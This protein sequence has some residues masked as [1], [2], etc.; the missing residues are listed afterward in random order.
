M[1]GR[2]RRV[3]ALAFLCICVLLVTDMVSISMYD[4]SWDWP[5]FLEPQRIRT[6]NATG[7]DPVDLSYLGDTYARDEEVSQ[8]SCPD[9]IRARV[10][11]SP[12]KLAFLKNVPVLQWLKHVSKKEYDRLHKYPGAHGWRGVS[13]LDLVDTLSALNTSANRVMF[14]DWDQRAQGSS[15][16]RCA[17]IGNGGILRG[18]EKGQEIDRHH[19][20]F[21]VN[22]AVIKGFEEDVGSRTSFYTFSTNT[23]RNSMRS[24]ARAGFRGPPKS[25][26]TRYIFLP[27]QGRDYT[28]LQA[29][30]TQTQ[31]QTQVKKRPGRSKSPPSYFGKNATAMKFKIYHPDF[32][33]Y[34]QNRFLHSRLLKGRFRDWY[35]PTTGGVMLMAA[36]HTCDQVDAY[37]FITPDYKSYSDHYYDKSFHR[38]RFYANHDMSLEMKVWQKLHE[39][40]LINLYMRKSAPPAPVP[41]EQYTPPHTH[42]CQSTPSVH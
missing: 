21:R 35:R 17:V 24:Y 10:L 8:T 22:G 15:C 23:M 18:S 34:I 11:R 42:R 29:V 19:Y 26:E 39:A 30:A 9:G 12:F 25:E 3:L 36:M 27:D 1:I 37:G 20:V 40:G 14:D 31:T 6:T 5:G 32:I 28:L 2:P 38:L 4:A 13:F 41:V 16:I 7:S 33:R